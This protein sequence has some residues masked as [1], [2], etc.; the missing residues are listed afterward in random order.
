MRKAIGIRRDQHRIAAETN[1]YLQRKVR[2][3]VDSSRRPKKRV[4]DDE[5]SDKEAS[6]G[7]IGKSRT[8]T[9]DSNSWMPT[10]AVESVGV[11]EADWTQRRNLLLVNDP[12]SVEDGAPMPE[13]E[14]EGNAGS[15]GPK[16]AIDEDS[17]R[18]P[19]FESDD[20]S[21]ALT[22]IITQARG[23]GPVSKEQV[24]NDKEIL[25]KAK[26]LFKGQNR[27]RQCKGQ[28]GELRFRFDRMLS[29]LLPHQVLGA[30]FVVNTERSGT[31]RRSGLL[32]DDMGLGKTPEMLCAMMEAKP[33]SA[34]KRAGQHCTL[35]IVTPSLVKQWESEIKKH[36]KPKWA[37]KVLVYRSAD[38]AAG[39][40]PSDY[41]LTHDIM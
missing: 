41:L 26:E 36:C 10:E 9:F 7:P 25:K 12:K 28:L 17:L 30:A 6:P 8:S 19:K 33:T 24:K 23:H 29:T 40:D 13:H 34:A 32:A 2:L 3:E 20:S 11:L 4:I 31:Q 37:G 39:S 1:N 21:Q 18:N 15:L 14:V 35:I 5:D 27:P 38:F 22:T 16:E